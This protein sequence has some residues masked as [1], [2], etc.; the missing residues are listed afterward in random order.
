MLKAWFLIF[1]G[2]GRNLA[3]NP[4]GAGITPPPLESKIFPG[5]LAPQILR[6]WLFLIPVIAPRC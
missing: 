2:A 1:P 3:Q 4:G 5:N 6:G